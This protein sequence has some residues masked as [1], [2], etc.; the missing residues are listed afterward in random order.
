MNYFK[1]KNVGV[2]GKL[3]SAFVSSEEPF[4]SPRE[5]TT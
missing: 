5:D 3:I 1:I 2:W 4:S